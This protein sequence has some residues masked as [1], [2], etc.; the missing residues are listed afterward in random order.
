VKKAAGK[1]TCTCRFPAPKILYGGGNILSYKK[2]ASL[3]I[4]AGRLLYKVIFTCILVPN[5]SV[6]TQ[7][8]HP[9]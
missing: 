8:S 7:G 1:F 3:Q 9:S 6:G 4:L 5:P 2:L